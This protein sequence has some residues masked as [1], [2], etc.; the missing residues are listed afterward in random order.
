VE[1]RHVEQAFSF[2][3][4]TELLLYRRENSV[5]R[6]E[7]GISPID[8]ITEYDRLLVKALSIVEKAPYWAHVWDTGWAKLAVNNGAAILSWPTAESDYDSCTI[9][10]HTAEFPVAMLLWDEE[11]IKEWKKQQKKIYEEKERMCQ[12]ARVQQR[13]QQERALFEALKRKYQ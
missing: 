6:T 10:R 12:A 7:S 4:G 9:E 1:K 2:C 3:S 8:A 5:E 13:E 11:Q